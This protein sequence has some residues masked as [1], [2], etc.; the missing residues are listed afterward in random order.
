MSRHE[1]HKLEIGCETHLQ[2]GPPPLDAS[3]SEASCRIDAAA[4]REWLKANPTAMKRER[5][6]SVRE[7]KAFDMLPGTRAVIFRGPGRS[8]ICIFCSLGDLN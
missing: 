5:L 2:L 6:A 4:D 3:A 1:Y 7:R 8:Q